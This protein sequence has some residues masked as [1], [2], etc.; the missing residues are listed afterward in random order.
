MYTTQLLVIQFT[1]YCQVAMDVA[2]L[3]RTP[4]ALQAKT[5]SFTIA[6]F[7]C[8]DYTNITPTYVS[9]N[10]NLVSGHAKHASELGQQMVQTML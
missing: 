4:K 8:A 3:E 1:A 7:A 9:I 10:M 5:E 6:R 2:G